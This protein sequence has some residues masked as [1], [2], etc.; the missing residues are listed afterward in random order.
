MATFQMVCQAGREDK[1]TLTAP[2]MRAIS[3]ME[4]KM[5]KELTN[6]QM[7]RDMKEAGLMG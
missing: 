7:G 1:H 6:G 3:N 5:A 4:L 2:A